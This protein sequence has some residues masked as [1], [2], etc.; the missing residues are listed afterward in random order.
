MANAMFEKWKGEALKAAPVV[1]LPVPE[2]TLLGEAVDISKFCSK[3]WQAV[4]DDRGVVTM[5]GLELA[6]RRGL[7]EKQIGTEIFEL[8]EALHAAHTDY[9]L[10]VQAA[11][12]APMERA[13]FALRELRSALGFL[14]DD[15]VI[16]DNDARLERL[17]AAYDQAFSQDDVA[18]ALESY[19]TLAEQHR[20]KLHGLG[21]FEA[22]VIA[23]AP[24][25]AKRLRNRSADQR[26][27]KPGSEEGAALE[28]RNRVAALLLERMNRVR[29][30]ARYVFRHQPELVRKVTSSYQRKRRAEYRKKSSEGEAVEEG[31]A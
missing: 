20:D 23:E 12:D 3:Y 1:G 22:Q 5:P 31:Q 21:G 14:F 4:R 9:L 28:L 24:E 19:A 2:G 27:S 10:K 8:Q 6:E 25:L 7:F 26:V 30:V 16:D 13:Q 29:A 17:S 11:A 18:A 15:G